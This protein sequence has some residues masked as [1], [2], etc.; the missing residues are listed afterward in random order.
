M[1]LTYYNEWDSHKYQ[2]FL[3]ELCLL[4]DQKY[5]DFNRKI[6]FTNDKM[7][8]IR[9]LNIRKISK[10]LSKSNFTSFLDCKY[11]GY[12]EE[13]LIRGVLL[14]YIKDYEQFILYL[15]EFIRA[16]DNWAI[17]DMA[18]SS[19]KIIIINR[20]KFIKK[21]TMYLESNEEFIVR[22]GVVFLLDYY[23]IDEYIDYVFELINS[24]SY[25]AY[26]VDMAIA[27]L[28]SVSFVKYREKTI[29]FLDNNNLDDEIIHIAIQKIRDSKRVEKYY[30]DFVL[31]YKKNK[32]SN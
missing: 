4:G 15:D 2:L 31:K 28:I 6:V 5:L 7:I 27:W 20:N 24:I 8:G 17:C 26:Y 11:C 21:I 14:S 29:Q 9:T 16:I 32:V 1:Q 13:L 12:Y 25:R 23:L 3:D 22:V 30:K 10:E 18:L 19:Y